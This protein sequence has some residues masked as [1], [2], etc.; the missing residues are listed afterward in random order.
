M[1]REAALIWSKSREVG[2]G[3]E[4]KKKRYTEY[5]VSLAIIKVSE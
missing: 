1:E 5:L 2:V 4:R 3:W